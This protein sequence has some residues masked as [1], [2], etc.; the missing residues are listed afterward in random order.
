MELTPQEVTMIQNARK[1]QEQAEKV[2][3][4]LRRKKSI[5]AT[6]SDLIG[7]AKWLLIDAKQVAEDNGMKYEIDDMVIDMINEVSD[8]RYWYGSDQSHC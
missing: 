7:Q 8:N 3:E 5:A 4:E 6:V 1:Q 2:Q